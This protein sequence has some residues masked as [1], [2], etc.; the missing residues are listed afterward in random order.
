M[1]GVQYL[2]NIRKEGGAV[3]MCAVAEALK[4]EGRLEGRLEGKVELLY[5][6]NFTIVE[7]AERLGISEEKVEKILQQ[8]R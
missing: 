2:E 8:L 6:M 7:I 5:E 4:S 1:E 3:T